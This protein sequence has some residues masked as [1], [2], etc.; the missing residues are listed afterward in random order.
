MRRF[1]DSNAAAGRLPCCWP[2]PT[3]ARPRPATIRSCRRRPARTQTIGRLRSEALFSAGGVPKRWR[4]CGGSPPSC[5][6]RRRRR[7]LSGLRRR[8]V[9]GFA[10]LLPVC[11]RTACAESVLRRA[12]LAS[13]LPC[14]D[15]LVL[16]LLCVEPALPNLLVPLPLAA[17][18][19]WFRAAGLLDVAKITAGS[20]PGVFI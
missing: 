10:G 18:R 2:P 6:A 5:G 3:C 15:L 8:S 12:G 17:C 1:R 19:S 11:R 4:R 7:G 16:N 14:A 9:A 20:N 13:N